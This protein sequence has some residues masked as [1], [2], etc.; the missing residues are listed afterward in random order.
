MKQIDASVQV[1]ARNPQPAPLQVSGGAT[2][3]SAR[4]GFKKRRQKSLSSITEI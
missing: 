3:E 1:P 4:Q 2:M